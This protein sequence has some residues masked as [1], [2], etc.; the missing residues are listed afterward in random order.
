[1]PGT[2]AHFVLV[3]EAAAALTGHPE[4]K[5]AIKKFSP[6]A[7]LGAN[8]PDF[9]LLVLSKTWEDLLHGPTAGAVIEPAISLLRS[10]TGIQRQRCLAWFCGYL[11]HMVADTTVHPAVNLR[12]G[13]YQGNETAHQTCEVHQDAHVFSRLNIGGIKKSEYVQGMLD[14]CVS[15][16]N[17]LALHEEIHDFWES[18]TQNAFPSEAVPNFHLWFDAYTSIVDNIAEEGDWC[19]IRGLTTMVGKSHLLHVNPGNADRSFIDGLANPHGKSISYDAIFDKTVEN[20]I[21][22]W[23]AVDTALVSPCPL[24]HPLSALWNLNT[25]EIAKDQFLYW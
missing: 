13:P 4:I 20:T 15:P 2:F 17:K 21:A 12:V 24:P 8:S 23:A 14:N 6:F 18:M 1:M 7:L 11:S 22:A 19:L 10:L 9:P 16:R 3:H 25:G 5:I